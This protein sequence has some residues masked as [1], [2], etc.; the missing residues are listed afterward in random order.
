MLFLMCFENVQKALSKLEVV[1]VQNKMHGA[2]LS[3]R[4]GGYRNWEGL[5]RYLGKAFLPNTHL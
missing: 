4:S 1:S 5:K 2:M 3:P